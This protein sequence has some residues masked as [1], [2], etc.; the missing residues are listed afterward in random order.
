MA[1]DNI[2][3]VEVLNFSKPAVRRIAPLPYRDDGRR[4]LDGSVQPKAGHTGST[5]ADFPSRG[6]G[7]VKSAKNLMAWLRH[8]RRVRRDIIKLMQLDDRL[9]ADIG[10]S[11]GEVLYAAVQHGRLPERS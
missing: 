7:L 5:A 3:N 8:R 6:T 11:R 9:L 10:L 4:M 2:L 1:D